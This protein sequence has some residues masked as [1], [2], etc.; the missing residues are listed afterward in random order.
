MLTSFS[1]FERGLQRGRLDSNY[2]LFGP[3]SYLLQAARNALL[4][5][6]ESAHGGGALSDTLD[7]DDASIDDVLNAARSL[8]MFTSHQIVQV[9]GVMKLRDT[10][11]KKLADYLS[12]PHPTATLVFYAGELDRDQRKKKIFEVMSTLT[13]VV[14]LAA[15]DRRAIAEWIG[16]MGNKEGFSVEQDALDFVMEIQGNDLGRIT[17][18]IEKARLYGGQQTK[19]TLGMV[20]ATSGFSGDHD[21]FEFLD[22]VCS[23]NKQKALRLVG[24]IFFE[25]KESFL[26]F[27]WFGLRLRQLLQVQELSGKLSPQ[28]ISRQVGIFPPRTAEKLFAQSKTFSRISLERAL[29]GLGTVDDKIKRSSLDSRL[30]ME[31]LVHELAS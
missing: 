24:E 15:P 31:R 13:K 30:L 10:P 8:S 29:Y 11:C 28:M 14:E 20:E 25:G 1:D 26:A 23:K 27:W 12:K 22:A 19:V 16:S 7:L 5:A 6:L 18:E 4:Q 3:D 2:F 9:R 17:Q 21:L